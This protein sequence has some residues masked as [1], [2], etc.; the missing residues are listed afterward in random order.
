MAI[1][2]IA[3]ALY[4]A[5]GTS[6]TFTD[7]AT[8]ASADYKRYTI[9]NTAKRF[10]DKKTTITV[11]KN[12]VAV[13]SGYTIEYAGGVIVFNTALA[14]T[15]V[16]TVSGKYIP[17][18]QVAGIY[19]WKLE[20]ENDEK[21][22][23]TFLSNG[24]REILPVVSGFTV[25]AEGYWADAT[26]FN[27]INKEIGLQLFVD[28]TGKRRYEGFVYIKKNGIE[29]PADDIVKENIEFTGNGQIYYHEG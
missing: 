6:V 14:S 29:V 28:T 2:G 9:T 24:W 20:F 5:T 1:S 22:V 19:N 13:S 8:T 18:T 16:V 21:D 15:D 4:I 25:S 10:W 11:K 7:E 27:N 17:L 12:G 3:G 23:T 26:F